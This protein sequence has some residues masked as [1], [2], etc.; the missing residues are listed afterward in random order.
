MSARTHPR[1]VGAF[2]IG[3]VVLGG[4]NHRLAQVDA[5]HAS[6]PVMGDQPVGQFSGS[7]PDVED[8]RRYGVA[9]FTEDYLVGGVK[10]QPLENAL[11]V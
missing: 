5:E 7:A 9:E 4:T 6:V 11:V 10:E 1:L 2:V 3:A 8:V